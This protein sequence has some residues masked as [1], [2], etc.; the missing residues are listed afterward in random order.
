MLI[1]YIITV[2]LNP[3]FRNQVIVF[4][5]NK[6]PL[7]KVAETCKESHFFKQSIVE[8]YCVTIKSKYFAGFEIQYILSDF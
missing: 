2:D 1:L 4:L 7:S 6:H 8:H 5:C 3:S